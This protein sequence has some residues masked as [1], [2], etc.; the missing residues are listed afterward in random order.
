MD[1]FGHVVISYLPIAH[2][3]VGFMEVIGARLFCRDSGHDSPVVPRVYAFPE[4]AGYKY[5][6]GAACHSL[7]GH[8]SGNFEKNKTDRRLRCADDYSH[9]RIHVLELDDGMGLRAVSF[10]IVGDPRRKPA[11][12]DFSFFGDG[13]WNSLVM[14]LSFAAKYSVNTTGATSTGPGH[15]IAGYTWGSGGYGEGTSTGRAFL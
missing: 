11:W 3:L 1:R 6:G 2:P 8:C 14:A 10:F 9:P 13:H 12:I 5:A 7:C 4:N 15:I